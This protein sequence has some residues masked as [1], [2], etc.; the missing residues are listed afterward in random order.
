MYEKILKW[1]IYFWMVVLTLYGVHLL[2]PH[3]EKLFDLLMH[4]LYALIG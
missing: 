1:L 2:L 3:A 4:K